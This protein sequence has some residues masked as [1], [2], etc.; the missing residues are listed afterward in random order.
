[1]VLIYSRIS[2]NCMSTRNYLT[3]VHESSI[4]VFL[5]HKIS[6]DATQDFQYN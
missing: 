4:L 6:Y 2:T 1:M 3:R 5:I